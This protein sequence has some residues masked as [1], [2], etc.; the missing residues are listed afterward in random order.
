MLQEMFQSTLLN[1]LC[2]YSSLRWTELPTEQR[3]FEE[4]PSLDYI[5]GIES[6]SGNVE[7]DD[8]VS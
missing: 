8:E 1:W 2:I 7:D 6:N 5:A 4:L 3:V